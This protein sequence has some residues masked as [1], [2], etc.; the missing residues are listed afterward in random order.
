VSS[1]A[2]L[3]INKDMV[4]PIPARKLVLTNSR[5][6]TLLGNSAK[7]NRTAIQVS[8]DI[9]SGFPITKPRII[10]KLTGPNRLKSNCKVTPAL[11]RA[12]IGKIT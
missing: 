11:A 1:K 5:Q 8:K 9:P 4:K 10:P 7:F 6:P 2:A 3:A 12:K